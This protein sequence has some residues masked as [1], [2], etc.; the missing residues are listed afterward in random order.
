[1]R[2]DNEVEETIGR[3]LAQMRK[4]GAWSQSDIANHMRELG[5]KWSQATVWSVETGER[6]LRLTEAVC[7]AEL[8]G[9][10]ASE[11]TLDP[12]GMELRLA[13]EWLARCE[14]DFSAALT[15]LGDAQKTVKGLESA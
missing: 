5:F 4:S 12:A 2:L 11:L 13:K 7:L 8:F 10:E 15:N 3:N 1:M 6:P 14:L 9:V